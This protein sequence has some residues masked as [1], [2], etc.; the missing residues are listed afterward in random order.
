MAEFKKK[1]QAKAIKLIE[2]DLQVSSK[3]D[4]MFSI[5]DEHITVYG[6][7]DKEQ[8]L[9]FNKLSK[10]KFITNCSSQEMDANEEE[11]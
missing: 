8:D 9:L 10:T 11:D 3:D 2:D 4:S 6:L 1:N 7:T 5:E